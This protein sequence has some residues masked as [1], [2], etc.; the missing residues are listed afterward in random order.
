MAADAGDSDILD[1]AVGVLVAADG[2]LLIAQRRPGAPGA[3]Y[4]EFPGGKR[5]TGES[6]EDALQ[7]ELTEE[8]GV[9]DCVAE[10]VIRFA[11]ALGPRPVRLHVWRIRH[12]SGDA[13]GREGQRMRWVERGA[14]A[15]ID[16]LPATGAIL[17]ALYLPRR[18]LITPAV[19][20]RGATRWKASF[21]A[22]LN[23]GVRLIRLRDHDLDD[24]AYQTLAAWA[25][26][27][28]RSAGARLLLDRQ[29]AMLDVVGADGLHWPAERVKDRGRDG[30]ASDQLLVAS[31]HD[32]Q[33]LADACQAGAD[34]AV[35]S[36]VRPTPGHPQTR[37]LGWQR[38]ADERADHGLPVYA[39]G[40]LGGS[41]IDTARAHN[42]QGV[43]AIR[44]FWPD[45]PGT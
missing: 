24:A 12:W 42:G 19:A 15:D 27:R 45:S 30:I 18:Y 13:S 6:M 25:V 29:P 44:G 33:A 10:P 34:F 21:E 36:A 23:D 35:L 39:L 9:H 38:W 1:I 37:P 28:T 31:A 14:L 40:G 8:I 22:A 11:H 32:G 7:R 2:R 20:P 17:Q 16:L 3:G 5:E 43:A 4:W 41:D 26:T